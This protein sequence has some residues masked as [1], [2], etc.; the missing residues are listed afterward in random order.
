MCHGKQQV[1]TRARG[2][3][4]VCFLSLRGGAFWWEESLLPTP[5]ATLSHQ[6]WPQ[7]HRRPLPGVKD[8]GAKQQEKEEGPPV[9]PFPR[10]ALVGSFL[11]SCKGTP[12]RDA[13]CV[14]DTQSKALLQPSDSHRLDPK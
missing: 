8:W 2:H 14:S 5:G 12:V 6:R 11:L 13:T 9:L 7:R 1:W 10:G 3:V 4:C